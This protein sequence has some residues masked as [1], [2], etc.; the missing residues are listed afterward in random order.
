[1]VVGGGAGGQNKGEH[2]ERM[3]GQKRAK[4]SKNGTTSKRSKGGQEV[5]SRTRADQKRAG[6]KVK[7]RKVGQS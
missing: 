3:L 2:D 5:H 1:M 6:N 7:Q 4:L